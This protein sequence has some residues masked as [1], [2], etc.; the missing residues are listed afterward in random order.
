ME[1]VHIRTHGMHCVR[2]TQAVEAALSELDGVAAAMAVKSLDVTSVLY[3]PLAIDPET[4]ARAIQSVGFEA[5]VVP[6]DRPVRS[7]RDTSMAA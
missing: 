4:I 3:E 5:E 7:T 2:C 6:Q 1:A